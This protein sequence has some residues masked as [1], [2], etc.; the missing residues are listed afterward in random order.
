MTDRDRSRNR[1]SSVCLP[2][3]PPFSVP[4]L[5]YS[6]KLPHARNKNK[7]RS[8]KRKRTNYKLKTQVYSNPTASKKAKKLAQNRERRRGMLSPDDPSQHGHRPRRLSQ[9]N[10][11]NPRGIV[12]GQL[13]PNANG[14]N[15][16]PS[17]PQPNYGEH[18]RYNALHRKHNKY[19]PRNQ[20]WGGQH[21][22]RKVILPNFNNHPNSV[23]DFSTLSF[24]PNYDNPMPPQPHQMHPSQYDML[25]RN[26]HFRQGNA[27]F[28]KRTTHI[29]TTPNGDALKRPKGAKGLLVHPLHG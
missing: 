11:V 7:H 21:N 24:P 14:D 29:A 28:A 22:Q 1:K 25:H 12:A 26:D 16:S 19:I 6:T 20:A 15:Q 8:H 17:L 13:R 23:P 10:C 2:T 4:H 9:Q 3:N 27:A 18:R 5:F